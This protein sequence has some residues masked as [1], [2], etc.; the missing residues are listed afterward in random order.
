M[1]QRPI[2]RTAGCEFPYGRSVIG[3]CGLVVSAMLLLALLA[4]LRSGEIRSPAL[5]WM[6]LAGLPV[7]IAAVFYIEHRSNIIRQA[8]RNSPQR[9]DN[10]LGRR[11]VAEI[12]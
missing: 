3:A 2:R 5:A 11:V 6:A 7:L 4:D 1:S 10:R 9:H 8:R 12:H